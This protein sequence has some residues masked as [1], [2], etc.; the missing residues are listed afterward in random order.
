MSRTAA[1]LLLWAASYIEHMTDELRAS[2]VKPDGTIDEPEVA[3]E[4]IECRAFVTEARAV[5]GEPMSH[6]KFT[7]AEIQA[8]DEALEGFCIECGEQRDCC[9]PDAREYKCDACGSMS[10]YGAQEILIMGL[11]QEDA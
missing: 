7:L 10:V 8:A 9:E 11:V 2:H 3:D 5:A 4:I 6:Q 1:Q